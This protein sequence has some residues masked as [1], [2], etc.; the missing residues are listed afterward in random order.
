MRGNNN[1]LRGENNEK[2]K[3]DKLQEYKEI[4]LSILKSSEKLG[5]SYKTA[6]NWW[7]TRCNG[8]AAFCFG[9]RLSD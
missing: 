4:G 2:E 8:E 5:L 7:D 3:Y 6:C 1:V 9:Y